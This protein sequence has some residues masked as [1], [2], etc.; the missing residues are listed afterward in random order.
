MAISS[1]KAE[2]I[3]LSICCAQILWMRSQLTDYGIAFNKIPLY[4][5]NKCVIA[6]CYNNVQ[7]SRSKHI[8]VRY[9]FIK[10]QFKNGVV[11]LYFVRTDYQLPDIFTK[12][13]PRERF[14]FLLNKLGMKSSS[15]ESG[16]IPDVP[17]EPKDNSGCLS[18]LLSGSNDEFQDIYIDEKKANENKVD[19]DDAEKQAGDEQPV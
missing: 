18:S 17:D 10:K 6:L 2:Y 14:E 5:D 12:A 15:E 9:H 7:H 8:E 16:I 11:E 4:C 13:L 1:T 19:A 3:P